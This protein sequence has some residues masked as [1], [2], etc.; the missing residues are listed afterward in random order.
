M[1]RINRKFIL[2]LIT[3]FLIANL[4][5]FSQS[6]SYYFLIP[7]NK[8]KVF[9]IS[10]Y[11]LPLAAFSVFYRGGTSVEPAG[12]KGISNVLKY[13]MFTRTE[14]LASDEFLFFF[15]N[16]GSKVDAYL[17]NNFLLLYEVFPAVYLNSV[18]WLEQD[19]MKGLKFGLSD[20]ERAKKLAINE[21][22]ERKTNTLS[23]IYEKLTDVL[24]EGRGIRG[25]PSYGNIDDIKKLKLEDLKGFYRKNFRKQEI[26]IIITGPFNNKNLAKKVY[27]YFSKVHIPPTSFKKKE[28]FKAASSSAVQIQPI[29]GNFIYSKIFVMPLP[30]SLKD[31][32]IYNLFK[33]LFLESLKGEILKKIPASSKFDVDLRYY[34]DR[35]I[36]Y[37]ILY[38]KNK[39][40]VFKSKYVLDYTLKEVVSKRIDDDSFKTIINRLLSELLWKF[41]FRS[42]RLREIAR[43]YEVSGK[44]L[45]K[46]QFYY[47]LLRVNKLD[48]FRE[49]S[50]LLKNR[51]I[52]IETK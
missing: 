37:V 33:K 9:L 50:K 44:I 38:N 18:L 35:A 48:L 42:E 2:I 51:G 29:N 21:L 41:Q 32:M 6:E 19:R 4:K 17:N 1:K 25:I 7:K 27:S 46:D 45:F 52:K 16:I 36:L 8:I 24:T 12:K 43:Y 40:E 20:V 10:D 30:K 31:Y 11:D 3:F 14:N 13:L 47:S 39:L 23:L 15:F 5:L 22:K 34:G 26:T 28:V 49:A